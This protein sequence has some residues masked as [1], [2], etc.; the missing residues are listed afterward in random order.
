MDPILIIQVRE[1]LRQLAEEESLNYERGA[2]AALKVIEDIYK[3]TPHYNL[4]L[5]I[6]EQNDAIHHLKTTIAM[7]E[8]NVKEN[9][10]YCKLR[11][12]KK[13][14]FLKRRYKMEIERVKEV[15]T[16]ILNSTAPVEEKLHQLEILE[17]SLVPTI[18]LPPNTLSFV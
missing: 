10:A 18:E 2:L 6:Q 17:Q 9:K 16:T 3:T 12:D 14:V 8:S 13:K 5:I 4:H 11:L 1:I 15:I 7:L